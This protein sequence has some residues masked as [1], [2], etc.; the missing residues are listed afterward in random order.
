M[1]VGHLD[2]PLL[3]DDLPIENRF[4]TPPRAQGVQ[5]QHSDDTDS[6]NSDFDNTPPSSHDGRGTREPSPATGHI[7]EE[8]QHA[9]ALEAIPRACDVASQDPSPVIKAEVEE[10]NAVLSTRSGVA[11]SGRACMSKLLSARKSPEVKHGRVTK[12][13]AT[14]VGES[15]WRLVAS[16][17]SVLKVLQ[18]QTE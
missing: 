10:V 7:K 12:N 8:E 4:V 5:G 14:S 6:S 16:V 2:G 15:S 11:G 9:A 18:Q 13:V 3:V 1:P 17:E